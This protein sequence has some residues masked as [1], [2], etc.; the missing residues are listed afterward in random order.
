MGYLRKRLGLILRAVISIGILAVIAF[1]VD[2]PELGNAF[3]TMEWIWVGGAFLLFGVVIVFAVWR[4]DLLLRVHG[5][6]L[7]WVKVAEIWMIGHFFN[8]FLLGTTGGDVAKIYYCA[9]AVPEKRSASALS[10]IFDRVLG[11]FVLLTLAVILG[12]WHYK[13]LDADPVTH[14][15]L[16]A[17]FGS[18]G[19]MLIGLGVFLIPKAWNWFFG[20]L[21]RFGPH[22]LQD[23]VNNVHEAFSRYTES[24]ATNVLAV[25]ISVVLHM[26]T[27]VMSFCLLR[28]LHLND[29][30]FWPFVSCLPIIGFLVAI[31]VSISG[32]GMREGLFVSFLGLLAVDKET[33]LAFSLGGF[34][35]TLLWSLIGGVIYL[36]YK[37]AGDSFSKI[38]RAGDK[39]G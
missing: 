26:L 18:F 17:I 21:K 11:L 31:P 10:I 3:R 6:R 34:G 24:W 8:A 22:H 20:L 29:V 25:L 35:V 19:A 12:V 30:P 5:I 4:W 13:I 27:F 36:Q 37:K 39:I 1:R 7:P 14:K 28:A 38:E 15:A 9:E 2:W 33:A 23:T 32:L 16:L